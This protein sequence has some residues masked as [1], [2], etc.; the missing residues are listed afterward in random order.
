MGYAAAAYAHVN[1]SLLMHL[2]AA[3]IGHAADL[4][5]AMLVF[6]HILGF[7]QLLQWLDFTIVAQGVSAPKG[8]AAGAA[9]GGGPGAAIGSMV[10]N[11]S[12]NKDVKKIHNQVEE[13]QNKPK[14]SGA[15]QGMTD[16]TAQ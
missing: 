3:C 16:P 6:C 11:Q 14:H 15:T 1:S 13:S 4:Q 7:T 9:L 10:D 12:V 2:T 5:I 8:V